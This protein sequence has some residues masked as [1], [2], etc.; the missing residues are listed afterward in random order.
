[1]PA[2]GIFE[3]D[4]EF[5]RRLSSGLRAPLRVEFFTARREFLVPFFP[6]FDHRS[7]KIERNENWDRQQDHP[8]NAHAGPIIKDANQN[9]RTEDYRSTHPSKRA[10]ALFG[11]HRMPFFTRNCTSQLLKSAISLKM[12]F[13]ER[14]M[15][16]PLRSAA[17][18]RRSETPCHISRTSCATGRHSL[19]GQQ[20]RF[21]FP[22]DNRGTS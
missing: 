20:W 11:Y 12:R 4:L 3:C 14:E 9:K 16:I 17:R 8:P 2:P 21:R 10:Y 5:F 13:T 18:H 6:D 15:S 22:D 19:Q 7:C 1:M